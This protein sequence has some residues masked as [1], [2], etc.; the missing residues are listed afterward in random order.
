MSGS[1]GWQ[2]LTDG[3]TKK[4]K[5]E[6]EMGENERIRALKANQCSHNNTRMIC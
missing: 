1:R 5:K 2:I 3:E 4:E 6:E